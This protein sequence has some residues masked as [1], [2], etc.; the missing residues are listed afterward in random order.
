LITGGAGFIGSHLAEAWLKRGGEVLVLDDFSSGRLSNLAAVEASPQLEIVRGDVL[1][2]GL[3][4][5]LVER[6]AAVAHLAAVVG[7]ERVLAEPRRTLAVGARGGRLV[8]GLCA[9]QD[10]PLLSVSSSEVYGPWAVP[11]LHESL[12]PA[13]LRAWGPRGVYARSKR[14]AERAAL[15]PLG[16]RR[17][18]VVR[19]FNVSGPRQEAAAGMVLPRWVAA[20]L[21]DEPLWLFGSGQQTRSFCHV[22]DAVAGLVALLEAL[23]GPAGLPRQV[24]NLGAEQ[25]YRLLEVAQRVLSLTGSRSAVQNPA[26]GQ[27]PGRL[28][29]DTHRRAPDLERIR[30]A[31]GWRARIGLDRLILDLMG[32]R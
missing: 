3:L 31:V 14:V 11:P 27:V 23:L 32:G 20:A 24:Y 5:A 25:E 15:G 6:S 1:D 8:A 13:D 2:R 10:K 22:Q 4:A 17:A 28:G 19:L 9:R 26:A 30:R 12:P 16:P 21:R 18:L 7:V 29:Q